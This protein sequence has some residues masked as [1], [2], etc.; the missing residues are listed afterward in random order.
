LDAATITYSLVTDT[1][2]GSEL[3]YDGSAVKVPFVVRR[4]E[5]QL[6]ASPKLHI[7]VY[8][9]VKGNTPDDIIRDLRR[10]M[11]DYPGRFEYR[12]MRNS[13]EGGAEIHDGQL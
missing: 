2:G 7:T 13:Y 8:G 9:G 1:A 10:L 6:K 4:L 12:E 11:A 3:I 5:E